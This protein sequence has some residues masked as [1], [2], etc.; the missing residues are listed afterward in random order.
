MGRAFVIIDIETTREA[1]QVARNLRDFLDHEGNRKGH[2]ANRC[3]CGV[4]MAMRAMANVV[5]GLLTTVRN[6]AEQE[7]S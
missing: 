7:K 4:C 3:G 1:L 5:D 2:A 6:E